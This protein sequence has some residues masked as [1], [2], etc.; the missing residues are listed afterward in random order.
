MTQTISLNY[1]HKI[2][3]IMPRQTLFYFYMLDHPFC[4]HESL[5]HV[6]L[7]SSLSTSLIKQYFGYIF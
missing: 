6:F 5:L 4:L 2:T 7:F 3:R 1:K